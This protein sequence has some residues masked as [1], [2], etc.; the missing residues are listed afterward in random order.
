MRDINP[1]WVQKQI[2]R[3]EKTWLIMFVVCDVGCTA[4]IA[5]CAAE[6]AV[7]KSVDDFAAGKSN[8]NCQC[9][10]GHATIGE[11]SPPKIRER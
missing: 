5:E 9:K 3:G 11:S 1:C 6:F 8:T 4:R 2:S 10:D 7:A